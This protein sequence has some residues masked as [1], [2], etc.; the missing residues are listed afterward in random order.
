MSIK[1]EIVDVTNSIDT[2]QTIIQQTEELN[3]KLIS[4]S[5]GMVSNQQANVLTLSRESV[6]E[7][8]GQVRFEEVGGN[9]SLE[10]QEAKLNQIQGSGK[11]ILGYWSIYVQGS[12]MNVAAYRA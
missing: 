7:N 6:G 2:L 11:K 12:E 8:E 4:I 1:S 10:Q 5:K 3:F 9:L